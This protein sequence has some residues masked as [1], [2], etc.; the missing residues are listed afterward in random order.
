[1][2]ELIHAAACLFIYFFYKPVAACLL[3]YSA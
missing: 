1:M 3:L 2:S